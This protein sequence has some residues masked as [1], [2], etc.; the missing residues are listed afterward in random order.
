MCSLLKVKVPNSHEA[1]IVFE[2]ESTL[3]IISLIKKVSELIF[4]V[5]RLPL[6]QMYFIN[7]TLG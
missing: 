1:K 5:H 6:I 7:H 4:I 2:I 3:I